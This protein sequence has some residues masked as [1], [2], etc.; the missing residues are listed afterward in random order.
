[1]QRKII[2]TGTG[3]SGTTFLVHL[4]TAL[5]YDTGYELDTIHEHMS[6]ISNGGL[7]WYIRGRKAIDP[8]PYIIKNPSLCFDLQERIR[9]WN[10]S[11]EHVYVSLRQYKEAANHRY[12]KTMRVRGIGLHS[13]IEG[14]DGEKREKEIEFLQSLNKDEQIYLETMKSASQI[15]HLM[16]QLVGSG[17]PYTF[18][19]FPKSALSW[20]YCQSKLG[21]LVSNISGKVFMDTF[22]K[23][24]DVNKIRHSNLE[25]Q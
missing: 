20:K 3:K 7:E 10:W 13:F 21:K 2:I 9:R 12:H 24:A 1:M 11:V 15:G 5:G 6:P 18:I 8:S 23:I 22:D 25:E 14:L 4:L 19:E 16:E 17:I